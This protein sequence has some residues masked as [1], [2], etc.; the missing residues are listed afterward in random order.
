MNELELK[1]Q[2]AALPRRRAPRRDLWAGI[3]ARIQAGEEVATETPGAAWWQIAAV[4]LLAVGTAVLWQPVQPDTTGL[5]IAQQVDQIYR[6]SADPL[7]ER[8]PQLDHLSE[9]QRAELAVTLE[10]L[11]WGLVSV[12]RALAEQPDSVRLARL[13]EDTHRKRMD[14]LRGALLAG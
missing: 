7:V 12:R 2:L 10:S 8:L 11:E 14:V 4:L 13:L 5:Q 9:A 3:E 1:R 6:L